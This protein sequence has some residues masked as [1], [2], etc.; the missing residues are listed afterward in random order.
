VDSIGEATLGLVGPGRAGR[1]FARSWRGSGGRLAWVVSRNP[2]RSEDLGAE[3]IHRMDDAR[4]LTCDLA[5]LS[6]PDDAIRAVAES[7]AGRL[8]C[9]F[10]F[11]LSG[12]IGSEALEPFSR[13]GARVASVH[14]VRPFTGGSDEDWSGAFVAVEGDPEG[15]TFAERVAMALGARPYRLLATNR[16]LY[17]AAATLA[18]GGT[19]A[20]VSLATKGW[21]AAG[22]P[23]DV[24]REALGRLASRAAA[25]AAERPF[26]GAFTGAI[27]RRDAGTV[28]GH[29]AALAR[30]PEALALYLALAEEMLER[31]AG[32]GREDEIRAILRA[33]ASEVRTRASGS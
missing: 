11:H 24:A 32:T 16:G 5:V 25:A 8:E 30:H 26:A 19:A 33:A 6:V 13:R 21:V 23:E 18:A 14:P 2:G 9:R 28:R 10:V 7:L 29:V 22:I 20:L 31:T 17:H 1:A 3:A 4:T 27:A 12:A 15:A